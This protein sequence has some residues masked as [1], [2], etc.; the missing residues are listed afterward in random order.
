M[1]ARPMR[2]KSPLGLRA[3]SPTL[4]PA[5]RALKSVKAQS[6]H[7]FHPL[8]RNRAEAKSAHAI[9]RNTA[10]VA[11]VVV[12]DVMAATA[13]EVEYDEMR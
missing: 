10:V 7:S 4:M 9:T 5:R 1:T 8:V 11:R 13:E 3:R 12:T 2:P 6:Q